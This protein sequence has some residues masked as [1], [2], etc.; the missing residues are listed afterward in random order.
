MSGTG[1]SNPRLGSSIE[2]SCCI[3]TLAHLTRFER[4]TFA[5]GGQGFSKRAPPQKS[6]RSIRALFWWLRYSAFSYSGAAKISITLHSCRRTQYLCAIFGI[7]SSDRQSDG[8]TERLLASKDLQHGSCSDLQR[9]GRR[10]AS[11]VFDRRWDLGRPEDVGISHG[12]SDARCKLG[13][14]PTDP[15]ARRWPWG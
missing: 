2:G 6:G 7:D 1:D 5:F 4:V 10:N 15:H 13:S 12:R 14:P 9:T 3:R 8:G 11:R